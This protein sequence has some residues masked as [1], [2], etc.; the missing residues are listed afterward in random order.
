MPT[1][2]L[3]NSHRLKHFS[4]KLLII[5]FYALSAVLVGQIY[6][7]ITSSP[8]PQSSKSVHSSPE[9]ISPNPILTASHASSHAS[10]GHISASPAPHASNYISSCHMSFPS[11]TPSPLSDS[12]PDPISQPKNS[13]Q[14]T[15]SLH[16]MINRARNNITKPKQP[17]DGTV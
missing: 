16:P 11:Q 4:N 1:P 12:S 9:P 17:M 8:Q 14:I 2:V 13:P 7:H 5:I 3:K 10:S 15:Q 6:V